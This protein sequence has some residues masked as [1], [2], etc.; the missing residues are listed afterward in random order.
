MSSLHKGLETH[1]LE[2]VVSDSAESLQ[3][4]AMLCEAGRS[5]L[6][7]AVVAQPRAELGVDR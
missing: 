3:G 7:H 6:V 2:L 4:G 1:C 5:V